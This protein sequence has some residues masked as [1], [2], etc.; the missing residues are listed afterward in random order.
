MASHP[1]ESDG[2]SLTL[3]SYLA[4][5]TRKLEAARVFL[6][7]TVIFEQGF[8]SAWYF[9]SPEM[10]VKKKNDRD[11]VL[12]D[13]WTE[14]SAVPPQHADCDIVAVFLT[15]KV[16]H[17]YIEDRRPE[18]TETTYFDKKGLK[19][20]LFAPGEKPRGML[21]KFVYPKGLCVT[22]IQAVWSKNITMTEAVRN[23]NTIRDKSKSVGERAGSFEL[24]TAQMISTTNSV[25]AAVCQLCNLIVQHLQSVDHITVHGMVL[26]FRVDHTNR[27]Q[28]LNCTSLRVTKLDSAYI[29]NEHRVPLNLMHHFLGETE[30]KELAAEEEVL[31]LRRA[32]QGAELRVNGKPLNSQQKWVPKQRRLERLT[33]KPQ[34]ADSQV[35]KNAALRLLET[36][37]TRLRSKLVVPIL[38]AAVHFNGHKWSTLRKSPSPAPTQQGLNSKS[39]PDPQHDDLSATTNS[40]LG[41]VSQ[42]RSD[43]PRKGPSGGGNPLATPESQTQSL[44]V[45]PTSRQ[46]KGDGDGASVTRSPYSPSLLLQLNIISP[47]HKAG[48]RKPSM[49][50]GVAKS[51][52]D[53]S[54]ESMSIW[55]SDRRQSKRAGSQEM[56]N[57]RTTVADSLD[58][59]HS[60]IANGND[61]SR[62]AVIFLERCLSDLLY[63]LENEYLSSTKPTV[64]YRCLFEKV[65]LGNLK[66]YDLPRLLGG[67]DWSVNPLTESD[68]HSSLPIWPQGIGVNPSADEVELLEIACPQSSFPKTMAAARWHLKG[69]TRE[70]Q[71]RAIVSTELSLL[72]PPPLC[73]PRKGDRP[74]PAP[75]TM[76]SSSSIG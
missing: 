45:T 30:R 25:N 64:V 58:D 18:S 49:E 22:T 33:T 65:L 17:H 62:D 71:E 48:D 53:M 74:A 7:P 43:S 6:P 9:S 47:S 4:K 3:F 12:Q 44:S 72:K 13:I 16:H 35:Y 8:P 51:P 68:S 14:F 75:S 67:F 56:Q 39:D 37:P 31:R 5:A 63:E 19:E 29:G 52:A 10:E 15:S 38:Q 54:L 50:G 70:W 55:A 42:N 21:Q 69:L 32:K 41:G 61:P 11:M 60:T 66:P 26:Q 1:L 2:L 73:S 24:A 36:T 76:R 28:L 40:L 59:T 27:V 34:L 23:P 57:S 46:S 20:F